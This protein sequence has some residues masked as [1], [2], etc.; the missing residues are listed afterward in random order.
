METIKPNRKVNFER[1]VIFMKQII[2]VRHKDGF[3]M[4]VNL[5]NVSR[6]VKCS[7]GTAKV[8]YTYAGAYDML[9]TEY[10]D[11][12]HMINGTTII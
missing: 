2:T 7:D 6:I 4:M 3:E 11:I 5:D 9:R 12:M 8:Y 1:T 10:D